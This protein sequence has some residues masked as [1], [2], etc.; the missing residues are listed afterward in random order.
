MNQN[1]KW[2]V[3]VSFVV[4]GD[5]NTNTYLFYEIKNAKQL[6]S[7]FIHPFRPSENIEELLRSMSRQGF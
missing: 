1:N 2:G 7:L 5:I 4:E 3:I 6:E